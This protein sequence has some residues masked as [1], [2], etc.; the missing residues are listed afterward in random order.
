MTHWKSPCCNASVYSDDKNI[1]CCVKCKK[2]I[3]KI[4]LQHGKKRKAK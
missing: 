3:E 1:W 4:I 2:E